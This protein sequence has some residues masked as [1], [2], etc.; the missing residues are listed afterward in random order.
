MVLW[1]PK[2]AYRGSL[3]A[4]FNHNTAATFI[5]AG[6]IL[7]FCSAF[8]SLQQ[9]SGLS[10]IRL[11]LLNRANEHLALKIIARSGAALTCFFALLLT[12]SRGGLICT[13]FGFLVAIILMVA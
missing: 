4:T 9:S 13:C 8:S 7:W 2:V 6:A 12:G 11:L 3:T 1:A 10:S 5:G